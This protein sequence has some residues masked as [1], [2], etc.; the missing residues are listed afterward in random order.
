[1]ELIAIVEQF[2]DLFVAQYADRLLPG[3]RNALNAIRRCRTPDSG[4]LHG[5][6]ADRMAT[7]LLRASQLPQMPE[8]RSKPVA[9]S[10]TGQ[11]VT[12]ELLHG[13]LY[14]AL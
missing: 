11:A 12:G 1:M 2:H 9:G 5:M 13:D 10:P 4:E 14:L 3:H 7:A 8:S 6:R